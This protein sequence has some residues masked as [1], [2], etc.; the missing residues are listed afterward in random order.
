M[1]HAEILALAGLRV[2][3]RRENDV[4]SVK[5][6]YNVVPL[7]DGSVYYEQGL[8][9]VLVMVHGPQEG[10][11]G[12][13]GGGDG[14]S[15]SDREE[16]GVLT[17][18]V[19]TAAFSGTE[20]KTRRVGD[21]RTAETEAVLKQTLDEVVMLE[22]YP[23][24]EINIVVHVL[25]T[26]GSVVCSMLNACC[27]ALMVAGISMSDMVVACS[28]GVIK[29]RICQDCTQVE[30]SSGGAYLPIAIK[31]RSEEV[32]MLQLAS[33]LSLE[34]LEVALRSA[35]EGCRKLRAIMEDGT[36]QYIRQ[37]KNDDE[38]ARG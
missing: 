4:R 28:V 15:R 37:K 12:G 14:L 6:R 13:G 35:V 25:E 32:I 2:D 31:A 22:L 34:A 20:R 3:G 24:S 10:G 1:Q 26:D 38:S 19:E 29:D 7:A 30:Q 17:V 23:K 11:G 18:S 16:R 9:K 33:R 5:F 8:N 21:R 27:L 36:K